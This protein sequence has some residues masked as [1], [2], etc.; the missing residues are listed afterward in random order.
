LKTRYDVPSFDPFARDFEGP[1]PTPYDPEIE[2]YRRLKAELDAGN[3]ILGPLPPE[4]RAK[5]QVDAG[6]K[7]GDTFYSDPAGP[8][9]LAERVILGA[10]GKHLS[11]VYFIGRGEDGPIKVGVAHDPAMRMINLQIGSPEELYLL[12]SMRG[13]RDVE[14]MLHAVF[15]MD[16]IRGEWFRRS[17][18]IVEFIHYVIKPAF[19]ANG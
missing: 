9:L 11:R 14:R 12:A 17:P 7:F 6:L 19:Y 1:A 10:F 18:Q 15:S 16:H 5:A 2:A 4:V 8:R 13:D 3:D